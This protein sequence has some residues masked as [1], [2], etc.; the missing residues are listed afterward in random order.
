APTSPAT[1]GD[2]NGDGLVNI[3]D[4][5]VWLTNYNQILSGPIFGDFNSNG[6][7]DGIDFIIWLKNYT[8]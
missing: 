5:S 7:V 4:Y 2:A 1:P 3:A 6:K 8:G